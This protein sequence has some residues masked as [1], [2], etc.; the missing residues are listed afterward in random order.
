MSPAHADAH[1]HFSSQQEMNSA[2]R[3]LEIGLSPREVAHRIA[4]N[5]YYHQS[6]ILDRNRVIQIEYTITPRG[7][8]VNGQYLRDLIDPPDSSVAPVSEQI[9]KEL[10]ALER[11]FMG[12]PPCSEGFV[13]S[14]DIGY[15]VDQLQQ[16]TLNPRDPTKVLLTVWILD[17]GKLEQVLDSIKERSEGGGQRVNL[18]EVFGK[19]YG[20]EIGNE[21]DAALKSSIRREADKNRVIEQL[22]DKIFSYITDKGVENSN[23]IEK[24]S[25]LES[26][27]AHTFNGRKDA[28]TI[29]EKELSTALTHNLAQKEPHSLWTNSGYSTSQTFT[30]S[31][32]KSEAFNIAYSSDRPLS[33]IRPFSPNE[34]GVSDRSIHSPHKSSQTF[35]SPQPLPASLTSNVTQ[36]INRILTLLQ[37]KSPILPLYCSP[38]SIRRIF[39]TPA[40]AHGHSTSGKD[41]LL[42]TVS[43]KTTPLSRA[44]KNTVLSQSEESARAKKI[45]AQRILAEQIRKSERKAIQVRSIP[46][47]KR[48]QKEHAT[49]E[50]QS[51]RPLATRKMLKDAP[52]GTSRQDPQAKT[53]L[54]PPHQERPLRKFVAETLSKA[55]AEIRTILSS[56]QS[57][58]RTQVES[59]KSQVRSTTSAVLHHMRETKIWL[60]SIPTRIA[61]SY[62]AILQQIQ[63]FKVRLITGVSHLKG[64]IRYR[65]NSLFERGRLLAERLGMRVTNRVQS[66]VRSLSLFAQRFLEIP[67]KLKVLAI[68]IISSF[69]RTKIADQKKAPL[70]VTLRSRVEGFL[71]VSV[72]RIVSI[73]RNLGR[74]IR[75]GAQT[76]R[77]IVAESYYTAQRRILSL[78]KLRTYILIKDRII[79][80]S[81]YA[82]TQITRIPRAVFQS[83][84]QGIRRSFSGLRS[85]IRSI[86]RTLGS[87]LS[88]IVTIPL[89]LRKRNQTVSI[90]V[91]RAPRLTSSLVGFY[92]FLNAMV[93][94][95]KRI[96]LK[97]YA[98]IFKKEDSLS[99]N[100]N[101]LVGLELTKHELRTSVSVVPLPV[102]DEAID[103]ATFPPVKHIHYDNKKDLSRRYSR[104]FKEHTTPQ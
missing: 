83:A 2:K 58:I 28:F 8:M 60:R 9:K 77:R 70:Q 21:L 35:S 73:P 65:L 67:R 92:S 81:C 93:S 6:E 48:L 19:V 42:R 15:K 103:T 87:L 97:W 49:I 56:L 86:P 36:N 51:S 74:A 104:P 14:K 90:K 100:D 44:L 12:R 61:S 24:L 50:I 22:T 47:Q 62:T 16:F 34:V 33:G 71:K 63:G 41:A 30:G 40:S 4:E 7:L 5:V 94:K 37:S 53:K 72:T 32:K 79:K 27:I 31:T 29:L 39:S 102:T 89:R 99:E 3:G 66:V 68:R 55:R 98:R 95:P 69:Q 26:I 43:F 18:S 23:V 64:A 20:A 76:T 1:E 88:R 96:V 59:I 52:R 25:S 10:L 54:S 78:F 75:Q 80:K 85:I 13:G 11:A 17:A 82:L 91:K 84:I 45:T 101:D 57:R 38:G 46:T